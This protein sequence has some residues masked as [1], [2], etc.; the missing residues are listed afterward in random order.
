MTAWLGPVVFLKG[1]SEFERDT[2]MLGSMPQQQ[3]EREVGMQVGRCGQP[4]SWL[5]SMAGCLLPVD[6]ISKAP[7]ISR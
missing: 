4:R 7:A 6:V 5:V 3:G 2:E 1:V